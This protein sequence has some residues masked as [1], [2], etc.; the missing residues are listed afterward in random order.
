MHDHVSALRAWARGSYPLEAAVEL[1]VRAGS[2][3]LAGRGNPWI[4]PGERPGSY[5]LDPSKVTPETTG[6]LS[7][8]QRR[9]VAIAAS[10]ADG[11][12]VSLYDVVPGLD[13]DHTDLVL[14]AVAHANGS[15]EHTDIQLD[16]AGRLRVHG[17]LPSLHPWAPKPGGSGGPRW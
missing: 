6:C 8:G 7:G 9:I 17:S 5:W 4:A 10:L 12:P 11:T 14:A 2:G 13:R 3:T 16:D 1:L 15:H